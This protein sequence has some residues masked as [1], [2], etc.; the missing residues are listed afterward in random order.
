[1]EKIIATLIVMCVMLMFASDYI[2]RDKLFWGGVAIGEAIL[3]MVYMGLVLIGG[4]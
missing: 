1:M 3:C 4:A 2:R